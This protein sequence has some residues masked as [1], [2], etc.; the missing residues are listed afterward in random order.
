[1][2]ADNKKP[3]LVGVL[4]GLAG[5]GLV[6]LLSSLFVIY[7]G[8]YNIAATEDHSSFVRW[9]FTT[10]MKSSIKGRATDVE[11]PENFSGAM[12]AAGAE[13]YKAMC[14][15]CHGGVG[16]EADDWAKGMLPQPP[17]LPDVVAE[18]E[19]SEVFWLV[20]HGIKMTGMPAFGSSH[21]DQTLWNIVA[22]VD[23]LPGM[24][25]EEYK[26]FESNQSGGRTH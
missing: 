2:E 12:I 16:S 5:L 24:T 11:A 6:L 21:D 17:H 23:Q 18:W 22:F 13:E 15:H 8:S 14:Q 7:T 3:F 25:A 9:A 26:N 20:K 1:M 19:P 10:T 4:A